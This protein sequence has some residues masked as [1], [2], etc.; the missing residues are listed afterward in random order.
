MQCWL[1][2]ATVCIF[3]LTQSFNVFA[4]EDI[5]SKNLELAFELR[6]ASP[7]E[8]ITLLDT[9]E[10]DKLTSQERDLY[11][12]LLNYSLFIN[13][14]FDE[15]IVGFT[16]LTANKISTN[17]RHQAMSSLVGIHATARNWTL[18]FKSLESLLNEIGKITD[19]RVLEQ[20]HLSIIV[21]YN[22]SGEHDLAAKYAYPLLN[23]SRF[24]QR[25]TCGADMHWLTAQVKVDF[26]QLSEKIFTDITN[27]CADS[28]EPILV[29]GIA[30]FFAEFYVS[31]GKPEKAL[32]ILKKHITSVEQSGY[33]PIIAEYY[34]LF[35]QSH[36][37][38][39]NISQ[40]KLYAERLLQDKFKNANPDALVVAYSVLATDA[41]QQNALDRALLYLKK[42]SEIKQLNIDQDKAKSLTIQQA[43]LDAVEQSNQIELL[44]K[45]NALLRAQAQLHSE[46]EYSRLLLLALLS[47]LLAGTIFWIYRKR[48]TYVKFRKMA[49]TDDLTGIANRR[50]FT[51]QANS[52]I[53]YCQQTN[54]SICF[55][56]FDLDFFKSI[57]DSYGHQ[58]GDNALKIAVE[59]AKKC[60]RNN[61]IIG[62]LGGEEFGILL[63]GCSRSAAIKLAEQC[64]EAIEKAGV[65]EMNY[66]LVLTASFGITDASDVGYN[67][68]KLFTCADNA[69]YESKNM[70]RNR[71]VC[72]EQGN[73]P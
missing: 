31:S 14:K 13:G 37:A 21:F 54:Q 56:L 24:S 59:A 20:A 23:Q 64:R 61:D 28:G 10:L 12:Y 6:S 40:A 57:N 7:N 38:L 1:R 4:E 42:Y 25:F 48:R 72:Y 50:F 34:K 22:Q 19:L 67:W 8:S 3:S 52:T 43:K 2:I 36:L 45:E 62:R 66:D 32:T 46:T 68:E 15:A 9:I 63:S 16:A 58:V 55:I 11:Q 39:G 69:L 53:K 35:A 51:E 5:N 41:E 60:C 30:V 18:G 65:N 73:Q 26:T 33:P 17:V 27:Q 49:E 44:D 29:F 47:M 71:V 70:G